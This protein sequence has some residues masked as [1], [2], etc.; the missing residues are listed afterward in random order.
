VSL[1]AFVPNENERMLLRLVYVVHDSNIGHRRRHTFC[2][3][4]GKPWG[5]SN[6][7]TIPSGE[8]SRVADIPLINAT[9]EWS[10]VLYA[11]LGSFGN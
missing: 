5:S 8:A 10:T 4:P 3:L 6:W 7:T 1:V 9:K 11:R 2:V